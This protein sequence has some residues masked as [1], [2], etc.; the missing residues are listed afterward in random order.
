M[1]ARG[2]TDHTDVKTGQGG[3]TPERDGARPGPHAQRGDCAE[4]VLIRADRA[5][6]D[7]KAAA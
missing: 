6:Y 2:G 3:R 7:D 4:Q 1:A 5:M